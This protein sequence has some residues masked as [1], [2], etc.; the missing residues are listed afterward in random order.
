MQVLRTILE[1]TVIFSKSLEMVAKQN[2]KKQTLNE[3]KL[4]QLS[5]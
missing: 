3:W 1:D 2:F 4:F 5:L